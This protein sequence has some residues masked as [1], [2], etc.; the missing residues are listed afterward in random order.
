M[1]YYRNGKEPKMKLTLIARATFRCAKN[2]QFA[3]FAPLSY[4]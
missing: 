4:P 2:L 3:S 1:G